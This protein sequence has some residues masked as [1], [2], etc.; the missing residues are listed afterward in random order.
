MTDQ[1][2]NDRDG[3]G[4]TQ[5]RDWTIDAEEALEGVGKSLREA[6]EA[7]RDAR[8]SALESAKKAAQQLGD[9]IDQGVTAAKQKWEDEQP[10]AAVEED[11]G[12]DSDQSPPPTAPK[13]GPDDGRTN[14]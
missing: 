9:A 4:A 11:A 7:S 3:E 14:A 5:R 8:L 10:E 1:A 12:E 13:M 2:E 6:W